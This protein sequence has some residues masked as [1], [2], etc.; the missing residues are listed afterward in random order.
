MGRRLER[1]LPAHLGDQALADREPQPGPDP[2]GLLRT[3]STAIMRRWEVPMRTLSIAFFTMTVCVACGSNSSTPGGSGTPIVDG[4]G[5][6]GGG[7]D[8]GGGSCT[9]DTRTDAENCGACG[10]SCIGGA[11]TNGLCG[12][13]VIAADI[14]GADDDIAVD[15]TTIFFT[16]QVNPGYGLSSVA[17]DGS[18]TARQLVPFNGASPSAS[19]PGPF[20]LD[21]SYVYFAIGY[22]GSAGML[23]RVGKDGSGGGVLSTSS[24]VGPIHV[25]PGDTRLYVGCGQSIATWNLPAA[26]RG[27]S[28]AGPAELARG[29]IGCVIDPDGAIY[30][31]LGADANGNGAIAQLKVD[32]TSAKLAVNVLGTVSPPTSAFRI[33]TD[34]DYVYVLDAANDLQRAPK[35]GGGATLVAKGE[36]TNGLYIVTG[37][38]FADDTY[39]YWTMAQVTDTTDAP[40][41]PVGKLFRAPKAGGTAE[42]VLDKQP[43]LALGAMD[44]KRLYFTLG[45]DLH[46]SVIAL[47]R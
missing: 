22:E 16:T 34:N 20:A 13:V 28:L 14:G 41:A 23:S 15:D 5:G 6:G 44:D 21:A 24:V 43:R 29:V 37:R 2:R 12:P 31:L 35:T 17:K 42:V 33:A 19:F 38:P 47:A 39:V 11:C 26:T 25:D 40:P 8:G 1:Q 7:G 30:D 32:S 18:G 36:P 10:H 3:I 46:R 45:T 9:A 27:A 4:G